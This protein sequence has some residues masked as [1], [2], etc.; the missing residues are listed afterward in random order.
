[1]DYLKELEHCMLCEHRCGVNRLAGELGVCRMGLPQVA[2]R[3][4]HPAP[5]ES[6]TVFMAG[7]NFKCLNCQNW[8]ISQYPDNGK[9]VDGWIEPDKLAVE[10]V[11]ALNSPRA[12]HMGADRVFFSGGEP[13]ISLP[14]IEQVVR[15][16]RAMEP[17]LKV[18]FD[19]NGFMTESS[20]DRVLGFA[21]S[22]TYDIK[23]F[24]DDTHKALTGAPV[25]PVLRNAEILIGRALE[26][27][28][29]IRV[30]LVPGINDEDIEPLC[31]F[32]AGLSKDVPVCFLAFR[33]NF[34]LDAHPGATRDQLKRCVDTALA[35]GLKKVV[36]TGMPGLPGEYLEPATD[37]QALYGRD[38]AALA[39]TRVAEVGC[40]THPRNCPSC[41]MNQDCPVK[42]YIPSGSN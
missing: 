9:R 31:G 13:T 7:C 20:L 33:P 1:M 34:V 4:L 28:W 26:R 11:G 21:N 30:T 8:K 15:E 40:A 18:N 25:G 5:P 3:T 10:C 17:D 27:V 16:A 14:Y 32:L 42:R 41:A 39:A 2:S 38:G 12:K 22:F 6:Y 35:A 36:W 37:M 29:E 23:A 19:T 24:F